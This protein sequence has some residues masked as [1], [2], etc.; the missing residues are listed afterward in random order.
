MSLE[1]SV[2]AALAEVMVYNEMTKKWQPPQGSDGQA[3]KVEIMQHN[4]KPAFRIVSLRDGKWLLNCNI[5]QKLKY[6]SATATFHQWRDENR[7][8]YGLNFQ[9]E[10]D[11][12]MFVSIIGQA[13]DHIAHQ[14]LS[15]Y[16]NP[17]P[18]DN[19][20]QD[21]HQ[22]MMHIQSAPN[23]AAHDENQNANFK[24]QS[25]VPLQQ[26]INRRVSQTSNQDYHHSHAIPSSSTNTTTVPAPPPAPPAPPPIPPQASAGPSSIPPVSSNAPP[27]PPPPPPNFG[28]AGTAGKP[29][30][31][32]DQLKMR[33]QNLNKTTNGAAPVTQKAEPEK[34]AAPSAGGNLMSE[35]AAHIN[36]RKMTQAKADAVD[37]K[38]NTS[39]GSSDS[40]CG[41]ATSTNGFSNGGSIGSAAAK[42]WSV[43]DVKSASI[44]ESPKTH[45]KLPSASSIFSQDEKTV[46]SEGS[47]TG[48]LVNNEL[49]EKFRAE[50]MV[51]VRLEINKAK[52]EIIEVIRQEL[53]RH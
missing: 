15:E 42:K 8:V 31:L 22:H 23:F 25:N 21:P 14:A 29:T 10:P 20:Y 41:T 50:L 32:A 34:P 46:V 44:T 53:S 37:S 11:A 2:A 18:A 45:R 35:L 49:L 12:R 48:S 38:S 7:Q 30:S 6:H 4:H 19:V 43:S 9:S 47:S 13:I 16:Q 40:G 39:N 1:I 5:H 51:E 17:H 3:S 27:P 26:Q 52:Q 33:S 36:K 28:A 24:K